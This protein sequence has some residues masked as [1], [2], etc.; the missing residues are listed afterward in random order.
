[1]TSG[2]LLSIPRYDMN[3]FFSLCRTNLIR[4]ALEVS[5]TKLCLTRHGGS[6]VG[7]RNTFVIT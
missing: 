1:M 6:A 3:F 2:T 7:M 4:I 5:T